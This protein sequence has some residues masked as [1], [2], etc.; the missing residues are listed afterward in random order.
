M[1]KTM[2]AVIGAVASDNRF[3]ATHLQR[4]HGK[5]E[6]SILTLVADDGF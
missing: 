5:I 3:Q 4:Q 6:R 2:K 1:K